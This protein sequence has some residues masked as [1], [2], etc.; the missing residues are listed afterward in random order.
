MFRP[1]PTLANLAQPDCGP[2]KQRKKEKQKKKRK[3]IK[4][5]QQGWDK[6]YC[7]CFCERSKGG[8]LGFRVRPLRPD[9]F[10]LDLSGQVDS[11]EG[12]FAAILL[13]SLSCV[14]SLRCQKLWPN[15]SWCQPAREARCCCMQGFLGRRRMFATM[16]SL[17]GGVR[18][19][20]QQNVEPFCGPRIQSTPWRKL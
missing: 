15:L 16:A 5:V 20:M 13:T 1:E 2:K 10:R 9:L 3:N 17:Y 6:Q 7:P 19:A 12:T 11:K 14:S 4:K 18:P 8:G